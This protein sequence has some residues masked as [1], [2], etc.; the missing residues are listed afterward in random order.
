M[1]K[2][3]A[4]ACADLH[5]SHTAPV[6]RSAEPDW[7]EAQL[8]PI[9]Q[10]IELQKVHGG[11]PIICAGDV[12]DRW[13]GSREK[14]T[15]ELINWAIYNLPQMYAVPGQHDLPYH[16]LD[17]VKKSAYYTLTL[18]EIVCD[19][20]NW[21]LIGENKGVWFVPWGQGIARAAG[22]HIVV[23]HQYVWTGIHHYPGAPA[24]GNIGALM[25]SLNGYNI[26]IFGDNHIPFEAKVGDCTVFNCGCLIPR[27]S[28]ERG[29]RSSVGLI[30]E[31][32]TIKRH[33]FDISQDQWMDESDPEIERQESGAIDAFIEDLGGL[34]SDSLDFRDAIKRY[35]GEN[36]VRPGVKN[37]L[38]EAMGE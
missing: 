38:L 20:S 17:E 16:N 1:P 4:I 14:G 21:L 13:Y 29:I 24:S 33:Y 11:C 37:M 7:Y 35:L 19:T 9:G 22:R 23:A 10:L 6:A 2:V 34:E 30:Y 12:F 8:R 5:L 25:D 31:D 18:N 26:A 32:G 3:I 36:K 27:K 15:A 28:D